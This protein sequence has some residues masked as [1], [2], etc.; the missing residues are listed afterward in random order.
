MDGPN[1]T[2]TW[3]SLTAQIQVISVNSILLAPE[4]DEEE[5][6]NREIIHFLFLFQPFIEDLQLLHVKNWQYLREPENPPHDRHHPNRVRFAS[7]TFTI[8]YIL[9]ENYHSEGISSS[10]KTMTDKSM[11]GDES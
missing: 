10:N 11:F 4:Q 1:L 6:I 5:M 2:H 9:T 7:S 3:W 8:Q